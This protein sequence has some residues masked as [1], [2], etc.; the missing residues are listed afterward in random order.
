MM[1]LLGQHVPDFKTIADF[2]RDN[3]A[4]IVGTCRAFVL[5]CREQGLFA[6]RLVALDGSKFRAVASAKRIMGE[7]KVAEEAVR[8][9]Q[10]IAAYLANLDS[11]DS[12]E[13]A[14]SDAEQTAA[15]LK[16]LRARRIELDTLAAR[17]KA[18]DR[19]SLVEG[20]LDARPMGKG[21]GSKPPSYNVQTA[22]DAATGLIVHHEVTTEPTD[23]RL[24]HPMAKA[25]KDAVAADTLTVVADAGYSNGADA[26]ACENDG[27][28]PCVPAN[29]A[30]N[31]Q[32]DFFD[33]TAF[34]YEPQ[35]DSFRC[36]A[37]RTLVRKQILTRKQSVLYM[38]DD[39]SGCALKPRC[40]SVERRF[41]K[42]TFTRTRFNA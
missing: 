7:R 20:E 14:D 35:T 4:G 3:A 41:V 40:T 8:I 30:V 18:E 37:G 38:A 16:A 33:R 5:F 17:L 9:D 39:C 19:T 27:I 28:T 12:S 13:P 36:P 26:A 21:A 1:W 34:I 2:R 10:Q 42:D 23:N 29:R 31:N 22:V 24:L 6:A 32:G 11:I 25:T 15:A